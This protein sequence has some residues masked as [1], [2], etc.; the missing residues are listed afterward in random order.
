M[1]ILSY[2]QKWLRPICLGA[3]RNPSPDPHPFVVGVSLLVSVWAVQNAINKPF[4]ILQCSFI[5]KRCY[6][7]VFFAA[8]FSHLSVWRSISRLV[9]N[10][11]LHFFFFF[12][13]PVVELFP[14]TSPP[15]SFTLQPTDR[16]A[17]WCTSIPMGGSGE[18]SAFTGRRWLRSSDAPASLPMWL[19]GP[20][21][22]LP[23]VDAW[24]K[25]ELQRLPYRFPPPVEPLKRHAWIWFGL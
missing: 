8:G 2:C 23:S 25:N 10:H 1:E 7:F 19:V 24:I 21:H 6:V 5:S 15:Q 17:S 18:A 9:K 11:Q 22:S 4:R 3:H 20:N 14:T 12:K 16:R 13:W